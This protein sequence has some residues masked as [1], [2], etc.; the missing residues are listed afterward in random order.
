MQ[1]RAPH[2]HGYRGTGGFGERGCGACSLP[3]ESL[4]PLLPRRDRVREEPGPGGWQGARERLSVSAGRRSCESGGSRTPKLDVPAEDPPSR[5]LYSM[6]AMFSEDG[7]KQS[8][9]LGA[10]ARGDTCRADEK[11]AGEGER[12]RFRF[13]GRLSTTCTSGGSSILPFWWLKL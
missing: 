4:R 13:D 6:N 9:S 8:A 7:Y 5:A 2:S 10:Q 3:T 11:V 1:G 12:P